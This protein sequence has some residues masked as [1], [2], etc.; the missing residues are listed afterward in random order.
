MSQPLQ[1]SHFGFFWNCI[2]LSSKFRK[3]IPI[4]RLRIPASKCCS[5]FLQLKPINCIKSISKSPQIPFKFAPDH[6]KRNL[7]NAG[8]IHCLAAIVAAERQKPPAICW[9]LLIC[10]SIRA[11]YYV[12]YDISSDRLRPFVR[13]CVFIFAI[14]VIFDII[15]SYTIFVYVH[16]LL[17]LYHSYHLFGLTHLKRVC[18]FSLFNYFAYSHRC[19]NIYICKFWICAAVVV[20]K[21]IE[22]SN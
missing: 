9:K 19:V 16:N 6:S 21:E 14:V 11:R 17:L 5:I 7:P 22:F 15:P 1:L 18:F 8:L 4:L 20:Y 13:L 2:F 10:W 3:I 12:N